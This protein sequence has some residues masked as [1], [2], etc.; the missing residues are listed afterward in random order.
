M[1]VGKLLRF[2][3]IA[4]R[5]TYLWRIL[6]TQIL[7]DEEINSC[8]CGGIATHAYLDNLMPTSEIVSEIFHDKY[9]YKNLFSTEFSISREIDEYYYYLAT[10]WE[11]AE[12]YIRDI[13]SVCKKKKTISCIVRST[14]SLIFP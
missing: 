10:E 2:T 6:L 9:P 12:R 1:A 4:K 13:I 5:I 11:R 7:E 3:K 8:L 14:M